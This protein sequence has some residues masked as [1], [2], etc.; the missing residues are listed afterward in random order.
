MTRL[1]RAQYRPGLAAET[2]LDF[3]PLLAPTIEI[4]SR[5]IPRS[6]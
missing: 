4:S 1:K 5:R 2:G 3:H 6:L